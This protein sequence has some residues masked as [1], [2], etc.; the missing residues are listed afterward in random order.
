MVAPTATFNTYKSYLT[1][2]LQHTEAWSSSAGC[3]FEPVGDITPLPD[4]RG[5]NVLVKPKT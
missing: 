5:F 2:R 3:L 1:R 4:G